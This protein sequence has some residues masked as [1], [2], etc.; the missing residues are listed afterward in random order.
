[1]NLC[2]INK[3][4]YAHCPS[5]FVLIFIRVLVYINKYLINYII[6]IV[7]TIQITTITYNYI[8]I[9]ICILR[10]KLRKL[11]DPLKPKAIVKFLV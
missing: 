7:I 3:K 6:F 9:K 4:L 5:I 2:T 1:M 10:Y 11:L 8:I